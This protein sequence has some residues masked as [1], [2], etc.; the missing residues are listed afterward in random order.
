[1]RPQDLPALAAKLRPFLLGA[2]SEVASNVMATLHIGEGPGIAITGESPQQ[3]VGVRVGDGLSIDVDNS[4]EVGEGPGIDVTSAAVGVRVGDGLS[5]DVDN[6]LEV[7][8]GPGID[9]TSAGVGLGGDTILLYSAGGDPVAEFTPTSAGLT[10]ALAAMAAAGDGAC[11]LPVG[12]I[13]GGPW[14]IK[15]GT[16]KG[17]SR[18][19]SVLNGQVSLGDG[20]SIE[21][22][23]VIRSLDLAGEFYVVGDVDADGEIS[24]LNCLVIGENPSGTV[25]AVRV[26]ARSTCRVID[27][28]LIASNALVGYAAFVT[29]GSFYQYGGRAVGT[30]P[31]EP[32]F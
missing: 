3:V 10:A 22:L 2:I 13:T 16:V 19:G 8:E 18:Y 28:D 26:A 32:Y 5:I 30:T 24:L 27:S 31:Y 17:T 9:V 15:C 21:S 1:M 7:G 4:L 11:E 6:S 29:D 23:T 14:I 12:I 25:A 20:A